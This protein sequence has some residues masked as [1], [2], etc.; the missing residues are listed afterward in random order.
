MH[1]AKENKKLALYFLVSQKLLL[2]YIKLLWQELDP[3]DFLR[4][5]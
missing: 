3:A 2:E 4:N 1:A 5:Q